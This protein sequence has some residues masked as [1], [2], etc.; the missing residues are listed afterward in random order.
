MRSH[1]RAGLNIINLVF[2]LIHHS[3][4]LAAEEYE[5]VLFARTLLVKAM[6]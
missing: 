5:V 4:K 2:R 6:R 3:D 1:R